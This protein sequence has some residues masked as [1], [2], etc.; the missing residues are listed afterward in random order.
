[1]FG[2]CKLVVVVAALAGCLLVP[3]TATAW[4]TGGHHVIAN[5]AYD[6]LDRATRTRIVN[7]LRKHPDFQKRFQELMPEEVKNG[8]AED[9]ERWIFFQASVWPD[10]IRG[11]PKYN[12]GP[13]H[14]INLPHFLS[15]QDRAALGNNL[16]P[17]V[18]FVLPKELPE[19]VLADLNCVQAF[20]LCVRELRDAST[21]DE[22]KAICYCWLLHIGGD[23]HQPLHSTCLMSR[24]RF[25]TVA[26]D[27]GGNSIRT[28]DGGNL[29]SFWD[30][31]LGREQ[32]MAAIV[33]RSNEILEDA[34][35]KKAAEAALV[36]LAIETWAQESLKYAQEVVYTPEILK[37]VADQEADGAAAFKSV[38]LSPAYQEKAGQVS[39]RRVAEAG[40]R[41]A[42]VLK[43]LAE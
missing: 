4:S 36:Q 3:G 16:K 33:R 12:R 6:R 11:T 41:L 24:G 13:W 42:A 26:G 18:S 8:A 7:V 27:R 28:N 5:I 1:M 40:Y 17:N 29:H 37:A 31:R 23:I 2:K 32:S 21:A 14:Y 19:A 30:G 15:E 25:N 34:E 43:Q 39:R 9:R 20:K 10:L 35:T 38:E 22:Q